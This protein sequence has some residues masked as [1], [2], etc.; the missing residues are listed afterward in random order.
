MSPKCTPSSILLSL[1]GGT[2]EVLIP[3]FS[4]GEQKELIGRVVALN[5]AEQVITKIS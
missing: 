3:G 5:E 2:V 4:E 1:D